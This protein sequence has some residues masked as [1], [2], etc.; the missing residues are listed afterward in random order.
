MNQ[1]ATLAVTHV[2]TLVTAAGARADALL[3]ILR[4][5]HPQP[6]LAPRLWPLDCG[7]PRMVRAARPRVDHR[8]RAASRWHS[9]GERARSEARRQSRQDGGARSPGSAHLARQHRC[10]DASRFARPRVNLLDGLFLIRGSCPS[11]RSVRLTKCALRQA[12]MPTTQGGSFLNVSARANRLILRRSA[13]FPSASKPTI[14]KLSR[15]ERRF[16]FSLP[17][18]ASPA[19]LRCQSSQTTPPG[20]AAGPSH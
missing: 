15:W 9:G 5:Q 11:A 20:E 6:A 17:W 19:S 4:L 16:V 12:S 8:G 18:T 1:L 2:P 13:I 14:W 7:I 3:G 10:H